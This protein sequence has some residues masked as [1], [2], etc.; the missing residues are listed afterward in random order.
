MNTQAFFV[1]SDDRTGVVRLIAQRLLAPT[2]PPGKQPDWGLERSYDIWLAQELKRKVAVSPVH[3]HWIAGVESKEVL[4]FVMLQEIATQLNVEVVACQLASTI[5]S[6]GYARC[7]DGR[8]AESEWRENDPDPFNSLRGYLRG[9]LISH[10]IIGFREAVGLCDR[11][12]TLVQHKA[13]H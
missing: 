12:W 10:D 13:A 9:N 3:D 11:G 7:V 8:L 1:R 6:W 5:D 2:D 4:D